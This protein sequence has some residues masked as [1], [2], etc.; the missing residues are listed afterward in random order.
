MKRWQS[1]LDI[2][3]NRISVGVLQKWVTLEQGPRGHMVMPLAGYARNAIDLARH[4][5]AIAAAVASKA[6]AP[7]VTLVSVLRRAP[8][9]GS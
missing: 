4:R 8:S 3:K 2:V 6:D 1:V 7:L 9:H 5:E